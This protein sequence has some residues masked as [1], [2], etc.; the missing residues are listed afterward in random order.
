MGGA[1]VHGVLLEQPP[2]LRPHLPPPRLAVH[3]DLV[4]AEAHVARRRQQPGHPHPGVN[5]QAPRGVIQR[6]LL[7]RVAKTG[8]VESFGSPRL[9]WRP[10]GVGPVEAR[11]CVHRVQVGELERLEDERRRLERGGAVEGLHRRHRL[12]ERHVELQRRERAQVRALASRLLRKLLGRNN[13]LR[14]ARA[15]SRGVEVCGGERA[16]GPPYHLGSEGQRRAR[17]RVVEQVLEALLQ[18]VQALPGPLEGG[19]AAARGVQSL[20]L[21]ERGG[22]LAAH[23]PRVLRLPRPAARVE[24]QGGR[25]QGQVDA[26]ADV[27]QDGGSLQ[28]ARLARGP[29]RNSA[30][31]DHLR[32]R[33][34][35]PSELLEPAVEGLPHVYLPSP[36]G[37]RVHLDPKHGAL[38][39]RIAT[40]A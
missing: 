24:V 11:L 21:G 31:G 13:L 23:R 19:H 7:H 32:V 10:R 20:P 29:L 40:T 28:V 17:G 1:R 12:D 6:L 34:P 39:G 5:P 2:R 33:V 9:S 18:Q 35:V 4:A 22:G 3:P 16:G 38:H 14:R 30:E 8:A 37:L 36:G 26:A 27:G 25:G 15:V